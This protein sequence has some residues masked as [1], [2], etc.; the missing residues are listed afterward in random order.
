[1]PNTM[2][3]GSAWLNARRPAA[4]GRSFS[5]L[6][7]GNAP[8]ILTA[9]PVHRADESLIAEALQQQVELW[10]FTFAVA[11]LGFEPIAGDLLAETVAGVTTLY[12][13]R[14]LGEDGCW[15]WYDNSKT[16]YLVHTEVVEIEGE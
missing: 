1:M 4:S 3:R 7:G 2:Q 16:S 11:D 10:D 13:V 12:Q 5:Y 15:K 8:V 14:T 6:R 9:A